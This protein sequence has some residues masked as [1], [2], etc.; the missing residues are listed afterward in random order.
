MAF[1]AASLMKIGR[2][3]LPLPRTMNSRRS[4]LIESRLRPISSETRRPPE[5]RS[6]MIARSLRPDS[7]SVGMAERM[8]ST[9][10]KCR[11]VTCFLTARGRSTRLGSSVLM[12]R[13]ARYLR[14]PRN[15]IR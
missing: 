1:A 15:A 11:N 13:R 10:S 2:S 5:K 9:S 12:S 7:V 14:K 6:S 3:F 8:S 4:R